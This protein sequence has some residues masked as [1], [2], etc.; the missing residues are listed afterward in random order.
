MLG[1]GGGEEL[2]TNILSQDFA[3][4]RHDSLR[5]GLNVPSGLTGGGKNLRHPFRAVQTCARCS[6]NPIH[7]LLTLI[8]ALARDFGSVQQMASVVKRARY[9]ALACLLLRSWQ[10]RNHH[11]FN[12]HPRSP[13][14]GREAS[15]YRRICWIDPYI[16]NRIV[17]FKQTHVGDP[18]LGAE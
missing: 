6:T 7:S 11:N 3:R 17:I 9:P 12:E 10:G 8:V 16:P 15:S 1:S 14:V 2:G 18:N 13:K 5:E 4:F